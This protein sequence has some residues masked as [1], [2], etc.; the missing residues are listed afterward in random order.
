MPVKF[1]LRIAES[2]DSAQPFVYNEEL[3]IRI[4]NEGGVLQTSLFGDTN[5]DYR[6]DTVVEK[7][8][9]NF[10]TTKKPDEYVVEIWRLNKNFKVG[11]FTFETVK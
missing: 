5:I 9:T 1:S 6:I 2:V 8:I 4:F 3:E 10:K 7:Y 11:S